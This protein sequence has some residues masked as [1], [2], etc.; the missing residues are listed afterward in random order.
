MPLIIP[1]NSQSATGYTINQSIRFNDDNSAYLSRTPSSEGNRKK[2]TLSTW[3]KLGN[4]GINQNFDGLF[5][6][7]TSA[8]AFVTIWVNNATYN[9][10]FI[11]YN[12]GTTYRVNTPLLT[13]DPAAWYHAVFV[14]DSGNSLSTERMR[15]YL[16]G[17]RVTDLYQELQPSLNYDSQVNATSTLHNIGRAYSSGV[18]STYYFDGYQAETHLL[19]G[20]AYDPSNFGEF[21]DSGIWIP[22][23]YT[24][25]YG[26]NGFYIKGQLAGATNAITALGDIQHSTAQAKIGSS[27]I[28]FDGN[29]DLLEV[30]GTSNWYDFGADG[31]PWT[32][33]AYV[34]FDTVSITQKLFWQNNTYIGIEYVTGSGIK[35]RLNNGGINFTASWSPS[36]NTWYHVA[37]VR[38][39]NNT[40][41]VYIDGTSI[42]SGT[43]SGGSSSQHKV[44][45]GAFSPSTDEFDG[46]MDEIR[47]SSV[48]RFTSSF[49]PTTS[50]YTADGDTLA[51]IHSNTTNGSTVFKNDVGFGNDSSGNQNNLATSG[52]AAHDQVSDSPTNNFAVLNQLDKGSNTTLTNGNL[53][54]TSSNDGGVRS[55]VFFNADKYYIEAIVGTYGNAFTFGIS[56]ADRS[57]SADAGTDLADFYGWYINPA[58][59]W[60]ASG[61]NPWNTGSNSASASLDVMQM[62]IDASD[63]SS[64]KLYAGINNTYY[65]SSGGSDGNPSSGTNPTATITGGEE[66][67]IGFWNRDASASNILVNFGQEGTFGG[68]KTAGGNSDANGIGNFLY[69]VPTGFKALCTKNLGS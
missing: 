60:I 35:V 56:N 8:S 45:I 44:E 15:I 9:L 18:Y 27:S 33:E 41:T 11:Q 3:F 20:Y 17:L 65:N 55:T 31:N 29:G 37:V 38:Q 2:W 61:S 57:L 63:P 66:W 23:E 40:T 49:T 5:S 68:N 43:I 47:I 32:M 42:G 30:G 52:L 13:R 7:V 6:A 36:I 26:T 24:G 58:Q 10:D 59:N 21:N 16:N 25:S 64:I 51:L 12:G 4:S 39:T 1:S 69:S 14:Y 48:A 53:E 62:A 22:K 50:E 28:L 46:Y 19:D 34:R 54:F 67:S